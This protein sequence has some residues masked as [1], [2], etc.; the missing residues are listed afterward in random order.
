MESNR[1]NWLYASMIGGAAALGLAAYYIFRVPQTP[2]VNVGGKKE[3]GRKEK[4][5]EEIGRTPFYRAS[6]Y[7]S[8]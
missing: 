6:R 8:R 4:G 7:V 2:P 3:E 5:E 1:S